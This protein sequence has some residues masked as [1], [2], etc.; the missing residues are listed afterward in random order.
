MTEPFIKWGEKRWTKGGNA[1]L[2]VEA[3]FPVS[4]ATGGGLN[5]KERG[6]AGPE[7]A[8]TSKI[9]RK[10]KQGT[11]RTRAGHGRRRTPAGN[12]LMRKKTRPGRK[13]NKKV[14]PGQNCSRVSLVKKKRDGELGGRVKKNHNFSGEQMQSPEVIA[15]CT[16]A[17]GA[18][19]AKGEN[20]RAMETN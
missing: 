19:G 17:R 14:I 5:P 9:K 8:P 16:S 6:K 11:E 10:N 4:Y 1:P 20:V 7:R 3:G 15:I 18:L 12:A 2:T 13:I